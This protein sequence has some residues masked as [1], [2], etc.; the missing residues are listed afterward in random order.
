MKA[1]DIRHVRICAH[2]GRFGD[3]RKMMALDP[4]PSREHYHQAMRKR[5]SEKVLMH[6]QCVATSMTH[7]QILGLPE[8]ERE[9]VTLAAAGPDLMRKLLAAADGGSKS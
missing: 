1:H 5:A 6:D 7:E 8:C 2:C 4:D 3:G 9:K